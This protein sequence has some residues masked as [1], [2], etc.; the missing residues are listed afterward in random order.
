MNNHSIQERIN[1]SGKLVELMRW[2]ETMSRMGKQHTFA[3]KLE[4]DKIESDPVIIEFDHAYAKEFVSWMRDWLVGYRLSL[5]ANGSDY[6]TAMD[7]KGVLRPYLTKPPEWS[8]N[9][10]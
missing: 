5:D 10:V 6:E 2:M 1:N 7:G 8:E 9:Q 3:I 4:M